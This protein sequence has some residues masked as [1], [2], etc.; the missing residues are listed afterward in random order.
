M[1]LKERQ[2][3]IGGIILLMSVI[4][5]GRLFQ[6]QLGP[7]AWKDY[8]ARITEER[9]IIDPARGMILDRNGEVFLTNVPSYDLLFTP[10]QARLAGG[11]DT[12]ALSQTIRLDTSELK[13][14]L[15]KADAYASYRPS[16][17]MKQIPNHDYAQ[18]SG[19]LW[20]FPGLQSKRRSIRTNAGG[21]ASHLLGGVECHHE[22]VLTRCSTSNQSN[23]N[24]VGVAPH[25]HAATPVL[26]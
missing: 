2:W 15:A 24:E 14:A 22:Q 19:E 7:S 26:V 5:I 25:P 20:R 16:P 8:A 18:I 10:R 23:R 21:L 3:V 17:I 13:A 4:F 1:N 9:E 6:L 11:L 12:M